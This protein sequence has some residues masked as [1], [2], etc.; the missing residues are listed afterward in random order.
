MG[1]YSYT[2][3]E[4]NIEKMHGLG[5]EPEAL[6][7]QCL[8]WCAQ[9]PETRSA[10]VYDR[11]HQEIIYSIALRDQEIQEEIKKAIQTDLFFC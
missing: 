1:R 9:K 6:K 2:K 4:D 11:E 8:R 7:Y 3:K 10:F 5:D